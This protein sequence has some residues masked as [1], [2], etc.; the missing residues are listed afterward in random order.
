MT[1]LDFF[2]LNSEGK[3]VSVEFTK[4]DGTLRKLTGRMGVTKH[5]KGGSSTLD[6]AQYITIY[7]VQAKGYRAINR[8]TIKAVS[9][10]G[11]RMEVT[12]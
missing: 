1:K 7:D 3:F 12:A 5:L 2:I 11:V 8:A 10:G 9:I 4:K 6:P